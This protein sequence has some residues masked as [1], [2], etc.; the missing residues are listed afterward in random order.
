MRS[1]WI[2]DFLNLLIYSW[3]IIIIISSSSNI[4]MEDS[5][6]ALIVTPWVSNSVW[7]AIERLEN[8]LERRYGS[9]SFF[10]SEG[11]IDIFHSNEKFNILYSKSIKNVFSNFITGTERKYVLV[12]NETP[13]AK[14]TKLDEKKSD[15]NLNPILYVL[16]MEKK[17]F[18]IRKVQGSTN[19]TKVFFLECEKCDSILENS[20]RST[21]GKEERIF[22]IIW[23]PKAQ[24]SILS[25]PLTY[26]YEVR[27]LKREE[28]HIALFCVWLLNIDSTDNCTH[29]I[30]GDSRY[31]GGYTFFR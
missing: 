18:R 12:E 7:S 4:P 24:D 21:F 9:I 15:N 16:Q 2:W 19:L 5:K 10:K 25:E 14:A 28:L 8:N 30:Y 26:G 23:C 27:F 1:F 13:I 17:E 22:D 29:E 31:Y 20:P 6:N 3:N 11:D